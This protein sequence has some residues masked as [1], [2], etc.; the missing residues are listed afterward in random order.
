[1]SSLSSAA[2]KV[3]GRRPLLTAIVVDMMDGLG[4]QC[5]VILKM[6]YSLQPA[7]RDFKTWGHNNDHRQCWFRVEGLRSFIES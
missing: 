1:Q 6:P 3:S 2:Q 7:A 5:L 4:A